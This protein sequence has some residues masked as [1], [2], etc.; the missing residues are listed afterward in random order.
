LFSVCLERGED[1]V[2]ELAESFLFPCILDDVRLHRDAAKGDERVRAEV[3]EPAGMVGG[4]G[5]RREDRDPIAVVE[6]DDRVTTGEP[7]PGAS[8]LEDC[9]AEYQR[10]GESSSA[11]AEEPWVEPSS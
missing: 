1:A 2:T 3:V 5:V 4:A 8:R 7:G 9:A 6:V 11:D 10:G